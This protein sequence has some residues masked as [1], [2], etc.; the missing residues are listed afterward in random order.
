MNAPLQRQPNET[1]LSAALALGA[2]G[3]LVFPCKDKRPLTTHGFKDATSDPDQ[4]RAWWTKWP[5][6][7]I[8]VR[9]GGGSNTAV[10]D[11]DV[12]NGK[13]G[14]A[15]I[16]DW[17]TRS[18]VIAKTQS[19]GAHLYFSSEGAPPDTI[20][21]IARGVDTRGEGGYVIVPPSPGYT[22]LNGSD[23]SAKCIGR[24]PASPC[25]DINYLEAL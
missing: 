13:N 12:K 20:E 14:Y 11:L 3:K 5:M 7:S 23:L 19:G 22:W 8:A 4:I 24:G 16:P 6:A 18:P 9:T 1:M 25:S 2:L 15:A 10:V 21:K 17:E